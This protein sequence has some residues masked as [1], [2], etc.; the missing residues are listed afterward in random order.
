MASTLAQQMAVAIAPKFT[1]GLSTLGSIATIFLI[2]RRRTPGNNGNGSGNTGGG[3]GGGRSRRYSNERGRGHGTYHRLVLGMSVCCLSSS[4]AWFFTTWPIPRDT[5]GVYGAIGTQRT[6]T[7]QGF[8]AQFSLSSVMYNASLSVYYALVI[9]YGWTERRI[10]SIE[11]YI[12]LHAISWGLFTGIACIGLGLF[13]QVG[14]DCW[15]SAYP[16]GCAETWK[17]RN[18]VG[19]DITTTTTTTCTRGDNG[20]IYQWAFYYAPLWVVIIVVML[21]MRSVYTSVR[22]QEMVM[23]RGQFILND[24]RDRLKK[25]RQIAIQAAYYVGAFYV[26]W[27]FPTIFQIVLVTSGEVYFPLLILTAFFVP[28][29]GL[30]NLIVFVRPKYGRYLRNNPD[31]SMILAWFRMLSDELGGRGNGSSEPAVPSARRCSSRFSWRPSYLKR[32]STEEISMDKRPAAAPDSVAA[33]KL[34]DGQ[35]IALNHDD[36]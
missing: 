8:F 17:N 22:R 1:A 18:S 13:N 12:H 24:D 15:I 25:S 36:T 26:T 30:L 7:A 5:T 28:I 32:S 10:V 14:W 4:V 33:E 9:V 27:F 3:G 16:I 11:P 23:E 20:S 31:Q 35:E 6:C 19:D 2:L 21:L 34:E 29:Q